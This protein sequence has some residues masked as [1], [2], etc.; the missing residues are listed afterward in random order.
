[1]DVLLH[2]RA[3]GHYESAAADG[4]HGGRSTLHAVFGVYPRFLNFG[5]GEILVQAPLVA[6]GDAAKAWSVT[7]GLTKPF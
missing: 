3:L 1:M 4:S 6:T 7:A 2:G 5:V